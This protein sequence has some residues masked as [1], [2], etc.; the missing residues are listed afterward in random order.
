MARARGREVPGGCLVDANYGWVPV[1][2]VDAGEVGAGF[3]GGNGRV[4]RRAL[5]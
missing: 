2:R 4:C 1:A 5:P 3:V